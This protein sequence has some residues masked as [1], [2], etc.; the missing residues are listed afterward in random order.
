MLSWAIREQTETLSTKTEDMK[1]NHVLCLGLK[2]ITHSSE[3]PPSLCT[4]PKAPFSPWNTHLCPLLPFKSCLTLRV[5]QDVTSSG[6]SSMVSMPL[7][8]KAPEP[9]ALALSAN[10]SVTSPSH[11]QCEDLTERTV[12]YPRHL[13]YNK[14]SKKK[15]IC[16]ISGQIDEWVEMLQWLFL[17]CWIKLNSVVCH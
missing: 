5:S 14:H 9:T 7:P 4:W 2:R 11:H 12:S 17:S 16:W 6:K 3:W 8:L 1:K 13:A 15:N 10:C